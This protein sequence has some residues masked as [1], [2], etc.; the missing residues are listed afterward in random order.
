MRSLDDT[1]AAIGAVVDEPAVTVRP[2]GCAQCGRNLGHSPSEDFCSE[3]CQRL[4]LESRTANPE[5]VL[6]PGK[7]TS[8][9]PARA[10]PTPCPHCSRWVR[11]LPTVHGRVQVVDAAPDPDRGN[12]RWMPAEQVCVQYGTDNAAAIR[13]AD[14]DA[15]RPA[16]LYVF[17]GLTCPETLTRSSTTPRPHAG[18][19]APPAN[20][21]TRTTVMGQLTERYGWRPGG[22]WRWRR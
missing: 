21:E 6:G 7:R 3:D 16:S 18:R 14:R 17:H 8:R 15:D 10:S 1:L 12:I 4:W 9:G 11:R 19:T 20:P 22:T 5:Q 13:A 2:A